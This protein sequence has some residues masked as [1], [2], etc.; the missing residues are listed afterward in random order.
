MINCLDLFF[1][2]QKTHSRTSDFH[3]LI[4]DIGI[5]SWSVEDN[6]FEAKQRETYRKSYDK[7]F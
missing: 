4:N 6:T 1:R 7:C 5:K 2:Q 3:E